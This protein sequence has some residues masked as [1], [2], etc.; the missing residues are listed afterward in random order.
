MSRLKIQIV[1]VA[2]ILALP[3][4]VFA[5]SDNIHP[6][7][8]FAWME[9]GGWL[10]FGPAPVGTT[11]GPT[12]LSGYAWAENAGWVKLGSDGGGP[13]TNTGPTSWGVN[14]SGPTLSGYAWSETSGWIDF[15]PTGGGVTVDPFTGQ[16]HGYAWSETLGWIHFEGVGP[17]TYGVRK[18]QDGS[19]S[20]SIPAL[21]GAGLMAL[22]GALG[23]AGIWIL[24]SRMA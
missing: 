17:V 21:S 10:D 11:I 9:N 14:R 19:D 3:A 7:M 18:E 13:Y 22:L 12:F 23:G 6:T 5:Q 8:R 20:S 2:V 24:R 16:L 15:A 4:V 1:V